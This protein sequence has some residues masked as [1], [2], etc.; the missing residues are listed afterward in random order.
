MQF[1]TNHIKNANARN[2]HAHCSCGGHANHDGD[3]SGR[4]HPVAAT[5]NSDADLPYSMND[6]LVRQGRMTPA[7]ADELQAARDRVYYEPER[8]AERARQTRERMGQFATPVAPMSS[9]PLEDLLPPSAG[10]YIKGSR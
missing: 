1:R 4:A 9:V 6:E 2:A 3:Y 5:T 10:D 8:A 7:R